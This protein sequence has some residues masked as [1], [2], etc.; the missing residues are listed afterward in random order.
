[1]HANDPELNGASELKSGLGLEVEIVVSTSFFLP[2][3]AHDSVH[4]S[5]G[6]EQT[7]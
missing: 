5:A 1:M 7:D 3:F 6:S 2:P 4:H